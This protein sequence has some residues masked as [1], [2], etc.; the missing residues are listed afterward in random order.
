MRKVTII[1][2]F[3]IIGILCGAGEYLIIDLVKGGIEHLDNTP[4]DLLTTTD[5]KTKKL[6]MKRIPAGKFIMSAP[7][8]EPGRSN[9]AY[10]LEVQHEVELTR[11]FYIGIFEVTQA[12][13]EMVMGNN[14][15][16]FKKAG[17]TAP[18]ENVSWYMVRGGEWPNGVPAV[19]SFMGRLRSKTSMQFDLPT[20]AQWEYACRSGTTTSTY[21]G[22]MNGAFVGV[23]TNKTKI[24]TS[25]GL[26]T[27]EE[28]AWFDHNSTVEY[29]GAVPLKPHKDSPPIPSGTHP[30]GLKKP[31]QWGLYGMSGNVYE[32]CLDRRGQF[33]DKCVVDP[34]G[35]EYVSLNAEGKTD[36][37][38]ARGGCWFI[39][40]GMC[41]SA[42][43]HVQFADAID[44]SSKG[45]GFRIVMNMQE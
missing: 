42:A 27:L 37:R 36:C 38:V 31:N 8:K 26:Q 39:M 20:E 45:I 32:W 14:P 22:N 28:I 30:V 6:V 35:A 12:Q 19:D 40:W 43:R 4:N 25:E 18:V 21:N 23:I 33:N 24:N 1:F 16:Y 44:D 10:K 34:T 41:R 3:Q 5:F 15:S 29:E 17:S 9:P 13:Y 2:V 7:E 11:G